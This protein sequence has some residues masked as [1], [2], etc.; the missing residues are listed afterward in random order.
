MN[1]LAYFH[2]LAARFFPRFEDEEMAEELRAHIEHRADDL[3]H[4]GLPRAEA[5]RRARIEFGGYEKF[6]QQSHEA[7]GGHFFEIL[8]QDLRYA[9]RMLRKSPG[10]SVAA[11]LT[12]ALAIG[13]NG[14]V[15]SILNAFLL[16]PL[17]VSHPESLY[18]IF[19]Q[20]DNDASES[21][22]DYRDLRE[23]STRSFESILAYNVTQA[24]LDTGSN[25]SS[26]WVEEASGNYFDALGLQPYLGRYFHDADERGPNSAPFIV[27]TYAF[28]HSRFQADPGVVGRVVQ[29][30]KHPFTIIGVAPPGFHGTLIFFNPDFFTPIVNHAQLG[31][32]D[33]SARRDRWIFMVMGQLRPG[34][35]A[36]QAIADL[37]STGAYLEKSYPKDEPKLTFALNRPSLYGDYI[38]RPA[39][40]FLSA[41][42]LLAG[43]ILLAACANLGSLFA[44]RAADRSREVALRL[45]LG[46][47]RN[48]ILRGLFTEAMLLSV[49]GGAVGL[50]ASVVLLRGLSAWQ[51]FARWPLHL[52]VNPDAKVYSLALVLAL[53]SGVFF[54]AV[55]VR[56]VLGTNPYEV[57]KA[58]S[59]TRLGR[60]VTLRD[61]L[62]VMQIAI[63][64]VLI[65]A[66]LVAVR[67][68]A[69]S[70]HDHFGFEVQNSIL[71]DTTL[72]MAGYTGDRVAPMQKRL[73]ETLRAIPGVESVGLADTVPLGDGGNNSMV[74]A[75]ETADLRPA[76]AAANPAVFRI[77]PEYLH[78][79][80]T[81]LL[82]GRAFTWGDDLGSPRVAV[83][84]GEFARRIFGGTANAIGGFFK[85]PDGSRVQVVGLVEDGK[86]SSLTEAL[87]PALFLPILQSPSRS[88]YLVVHFRAGLSSSEEIAA[89]RS[90]LRQ[91][92]SGLPMHI[93][94]RYGQLGA[95]LFGPRMATLSLGVLGAM[96]AVLSITGLFGMA[97]YSVSKRMRELGIRLALGAQRKEILEAALGRPFRLLAF[98]SAVGLVLGVLGSR[99]IASL[100]DKATPSDPLVLGGV[101]V[102]MAL[103]GLLATW[104]PAQRALAVNPMMLLRDE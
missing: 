66:S 20:P 35:T 42:M 58:G 96:G 62:L 29:L 81:A 100:V 67:G 55:P 95:L 89:I 71:A 103:L 36:T 88:T 91:L 44:A 3:E 53:V 33:M 57:V 83:V 46:S 12:L 23:R 61:V 70:L 39:R 11:V 30:D 22:P 97:A 43:L 7:M 10:F 26:A 17:D 93:E 86:Y 34:V 32:N 4:S 102:A 73:V 85:M 84:N 63:C 21:Y 49:A 8:A 54:G 6:R 19:R 14:V 47:S 15:F 13:A 9:T 65:T 37:N 72:D 77:S 80:G 69:R 52:N 38:G 18:A 99:V 31:D 60:R 1:F 2:S 48:R 25:A 101:I 78:A 24:G 40:Q 90:G 76:N 75:G 68:L 27:L 50:L 79:S 82:S 59:S 94:T 56:Q 41:L 74:F 45:A 16:R 5:V 51:P 104:I 87:Q 98:G 92:D 28:W 64:G